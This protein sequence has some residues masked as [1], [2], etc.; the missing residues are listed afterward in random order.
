MGGGGD[1]GKYIDEHLVCN[2]AVINR[3]GG[4]VLL[5]ATIAIPDDLSPADREQC[6][7][8]EMLHVFGLIDHPDDRMPS[9]L[10]DALT[11]TDD[12]LVLL[13]AFYDPRV[14]APQDGADPLPTVRAANAEILQ[15]PDP[16]TV[17]ATQP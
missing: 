3:P 7:R 12:D 9:V 10:R 11:P 16:R 14:Q 6:A 17:A 2:A 5:R 8:H 4:H 1:G 15:S 13:R